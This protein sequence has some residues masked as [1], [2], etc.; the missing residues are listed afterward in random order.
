MSTQQTTT[1][2][3]QANQA[4]ANTQVEPQAVPL[5]THKSVLDKM[6]QY[7]KEAKELK[8]QVDQQKNAELAKNNEWKTLYEQE[9]QRAEEAQTSKKKLQDSFINERKFSALKDEASKLGLIPQ[10]LQDLELLDLA[11]I[12][13]ETTST[14]KLNVLGAKTFAERVK[15][16]KPYLFNSTPPAVNTG[17]VRA[18]DSS[19]PVTATDVYAAEKA[20][21]KSG[22]Q[23]DHD[24]YK[25]LALKYKKQR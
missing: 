5:T 19:A 25:E 1:E 11:D 6:H 18:V 3:T 17:G 16:L 13:I 12:Q 23:E 20:W 15:A 2:T 10:A 7:Q 8:E 9:K 24:S 21:R 22:K 4:G 14:G